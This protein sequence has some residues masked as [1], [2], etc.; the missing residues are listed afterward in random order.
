MKETNSN[1][2]NAYEIINDNE[3]L[4]GFFRNQVTS[5]D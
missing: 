1:K 3:K 2:M 4:S 5:Y